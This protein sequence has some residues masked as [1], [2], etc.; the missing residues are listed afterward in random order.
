MKRR[1]NNYT[2]CFLVL[3]L[4]CLQVTGQYQPDILGN[5]FEMA[6]IQQPDDYEGKVTCSVIRKLTPEKSPAGVL[7]IHGFNDYFFQE[8]MADQYIRHGIQ[9][10]AVDLR[11]YGRSIL[12]NQ[13]MNNV[14]DLREYFADIDTAL[15]IMRQEGIKTILLSGHSTGGLI[16]TYYAQQRQKHPLFNAIFLNS[17][18]FDFNAPVP[19]DKTPI[20]KIARQGA[21]TPDSLNK[22]GTS[23]L[24]GESLHRSGKG[25]WNYDLNWKP[26]IA[27]AVNYG[28]INAIYSAQQQL[29]RGR[30][31]R[32]PLLIMYSDNT[33]RP[34]NFSDSMYT[35]D[36]VLD[37]KDIAEIGASIKAR[38]KTLRVIQHGMH[39]L[40]LS[41]KPTRENVYR[42]LFAWLGTDDHFARVLAGKKS[43]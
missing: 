8:E 17:P 27:P 42:E 7:Y 13:K 10:Y 5:G 31:I 37:V 35:G 30:K 2:I 29:L 11:K 40:V 18:F 6:T 41:P 9:F 22:R 39:D 20:P 28:W 15:K 3:V 25:E 33:V 19:T 36:A 4:S 1:I 38:R 14:R 23:T 43:D 34:T 26:F 32:Q 12:P 21:L 16:V 24:Y